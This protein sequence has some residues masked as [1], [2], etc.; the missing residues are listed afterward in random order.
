MPSLRENDIRALASPHSFARG[1]GYYNAGAVL[2]A[3]RIGNELSAYCRGSR[4]ASY[5]L[6]VQLGPGG[7]VAAHC[8]C[9]YDWGGICK[10]IVAL[11]LAWVHSPEEFQETATA[12][13]RLAGKSKEELITLVQEMLKRDPELERLLD[14]PL[15]PDPD[16]P[17]NLDAFRRQ[18]DFLL[19]REFP[20]PQELAF[21]LAAM[22][23]TAD[24]FAA[25]GNWN[26]AGALYHLIL[27]E[28]VPSYDRLYDEYGEIAGVL[29]ECAAGLGSCLMDGTPDDIFRRAWFDALLEA[30]FMDVRMGGIDLAYPAREILVER[31]S[32]EEWHA[33]EARVREKLHSLTSEYSSWERE[34][35]VNLLSERLER[36]KREA[37]ISDLI[38]ELG[39]T[40]QQAFEL[41]RQGRFGEAI[42]VAE[43]HF[44]DLPGLVLQFADELVQAG[45]I[46]EAVAYVTSQLGSKS[47]SSY[48]TFLAQM[49]EKERDHETALR[50]R[51]RLFQEWPNLVNYHDLREAAKRV[52]GWDSIR[53]GLIRKLEGDGQWGLLIE[54][55]LEEGEVSRA[56]A[57]LPRERWARHDLKVARAAE[58]AHPQAAIEIYARRVERLIAARGRGNYQEAAILLQRIKGLYHQQRKSAGWDEFLAELR[59]RHARLPALRDEL[60]KAGL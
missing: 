57:L 30:E 13:E 35:L 52:E 11:L 48:F 8:T 60:N 25:K 46:S 12:D 59:Q 26:A 1:A 16:S 31:A 15:Q 27:R 29:G 7:V 34:S 18:I 38:F 54:I 58:E 17:H 56:L 24:R 28:I 41:I 44:V 49:A 37:E 36:A 5:R 3:R 50:W 22:A 42:A 43:E 47:N 32:E 19:E 10:H 23:E 21:E 51:I 2:E 6:S 33:I 55:A 45:G 4:G 53:P 14:L 9:P 40:K 39:S 20:D